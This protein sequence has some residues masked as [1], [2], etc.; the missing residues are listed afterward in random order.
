MPEDATATG[1]LEASV[2]ALEPLYAPHEEPN[3]HRVRGETG[4]PARIVPHR[5]PT[6]IAI[7]QNLRGL[8][9]RWRVT[10]YPGASETT[11]ELLHHW[12]GR[13]HVLALGEG[14]QVPFRYYFCQREAIETLIY[15][16]EVCRLTS[17]SGITAEFTAA[18]D[19]D[20]QPGEAARR[21][22][23]G[24]H[25]GEDAW[26][27]YAFKL[28]TGAG[29][30]K[31]MSLAI[32]WS[33]FHALR[34]SDSP[35]ARHFVVVAPNLTVF[36]RLKDDFKPSRGGGDIF[37]HDPLIPVAWR[38][39]WNLSVVL[40]DEASGAATGGTLYL[41]NVHRLYEPTTRRK[42]EAETFDWMG[43][44]VSK[45]KALDTGAALRARIAEHKRV[46]VL[47]DEAHHL[48]DPGSAWSEAIVKMHES[49][50]Q[51]GG[52]SAQLDFSATPKDNAG[53]I[54]KHVVC[55]TPLGEAVDA[56]IVK[57]PVL[58]RGKRWADR[59]S[60]DAS[61]Q[62]QEQLLVGYERWKMSHE[63]WT[64]SG[65]KPLLFVMTEDTEAAN[66]IAQRLNTDPLYKEL[67]ARTVNLHTKLKGKIKWIGGRRN[68]HPEFIISESEISDEDLKE[69][70]QLSRDIDSDANPYRCI[71]SVLMLREGWDVRNVTTIVPLRPYSSKANI[72]PEQT[73][74]R[75]LRRM[76]PPAAETTVN[77]VVTVVE[78]PAFTSLYRE[79]LSQEGLEITEIDA[80]EVTRTTVTIFPDADKKDFAALEIEL[81]SLTGGFLRT[82]LLGGLTSEDIRKAFEKYRPLDLGE[83]RT[84][85]LQYE[86]RHLFTDEVV[87]R[88]EIKLPLLENPIGAIAFFRE[89]LDTITALKG[90]HV[91]L[92]P[93]LETFLTEILFGQKIELFDPRL[94]SRLS[95]H[96]DVR[97]HIRATFV[98][99]IVARTTT[100]VKRLSSGTRVKLSDWK[101]F[102]VTQSA[103]HPAIPASRT[104]FNLVPCNR[105]LE[106]AM[107]QTLDNTLKDVAAFAKNAGPQAVRIDYLTD[108]KRLSLYTPD[109]F[110]RK[111]DGSYVLVETKGRVDKDVPLKASAAVSWCKAASAAGVKWE[112]LYVPEGVFLDFSGEL[113]TELQSAC[114]THLADLITERVEPQLTLGLGESAED[115]ASLGGF[116]SPEDEAVL[117]DK[118][119]K[120]VSQAI[121]V[122]RFLE[123]K[124]D[125]SFADA[126]TS[127]LGPIDDMAKALLRDY[128]AGAVPEAEPELTQ[129]FTGDLS[130]LR[131]E[132]RGSVEWNG[133]SLR[134]LLVDGSGV[135]PIGVLRWTLNYAKSPRANFGGI[136]D[137]IR[138]QMGPISTREFAKQI[139]GVNK[140][141][142]NHVAHQ[143][144]PLTDVEKARQGLREWI[145][146]LAE[147]VR[148]RRREIS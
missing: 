68:G 37:D 90:T 74:G 82:A 46:M 95:Q 78:H 57:T 144:I 70:R 131:Q 113:I 102:Q 100:E 140:F 43:P 83:V 18:P 80:D 107:A 49:L 20:G 40:Q 34:E 55:D 124:S 31:V 62:Y 69:L 129:F 118:I 23:L 15:L 141:R 134:K 16:Y 101:P 56:G 36:E 35:L 1:A 5:R 121:A 139:E 120:H 54:F 44:A 17:L 60:Q 85:T 61:E 76:T 94:L 147:M 92:A 138:T 96:Q 3:R 143:D 21:A 39:D 9:R 53:R 12:F 64:P 128:L 135:M 98:P 86:E 116:V 122:F 13:D 26:P 114:A 89:E 132:E 58:G 130:S 148:K 22:S 136:F 126:F 125:A 142:N 93:L 72:L 30:T 14:I 51:D 75:G 110:A 33:Y 41:T 104:L 115:A 97:E 73:L 67:N 47:N 50:G 127:L 103:T 71:V 42:S 133:S 10:D 19:E 29:K 6:P 117:P 111:I 145:G 59:P 119:K 52:L 25:P 11:R 88:M 27:R 2:S 109:F 65:K 84:E 66:Q 91:V 87:K 24:I 105:K 112:Y 63:E 38:G 81:P 45:T 8:V 106:V 77:E 32:V 79:Q 137:A 146:A 4:G 28:A 108:Q 7:A 48:W 99:L 123:R